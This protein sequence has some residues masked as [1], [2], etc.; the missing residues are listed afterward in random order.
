MFIN[1]KYKMT[2]NKID[3][4]N[5]NSC[6][7]FGLSCK[8]RRYPIFGVAFGLLFPISA[9]TFDLI[10]RGY[11]INMIGQMHIENPFHFVIDMAPLILGFVAYLL[12]LKIQKDQTKIDIYID[13]QTKYIDKVSSFAKEVGKGNYQI[14][15][16]DTIDE[17]DPLF[18]VLV[19]MKDDLLLSSIKEKDQNWVIKGRDK[20]SG[21]LREYTDLKELSYHVLETL[22]NYIGVIQGS[23]YIYDEE[24]KVLVNYATYAYSR[25]K[26][27]NQ[28]FKIGE[29]LI[30]QAAYELDT[31]YRTE[32]PEYYTTITSGILGKKKPGSILIVPLISDEKLRGVIEIA[33]IENNLDKKVIS[34]VEGISNIIG[35]SI[36]SLLINFKTQKLLDES[37]RMTEELQENE[38]ELRQNAEEMIATQEELEKAN[39]DLEQKIKEVQDAQH[40]QY[41]LLENASEVITIYDQQGV[42]QYESPSVKNILGYSHKDTVGTNGLDRVSEATRNIVEET[43][44]NIMK[45]PL[46]PITVEFEYYK[47]DGSLIW[48]E[49]ICRNL[50][51]NPIINGILF[52]TRDITLRKL[53]EKEQR[54]RGQ[55]QAL[56]E[57]SQDLI[58]RLSLQGKIYYVNPVFEKYTG[59]NAKKVNNKLITDSEVNNEIVNFFN[60]TLQLLV[61]NPIIQENEFELNSSLGKRYMSVNSI[62]EFNENKELETIL[63]VAHDI[64][65]RKE[66]EIQIEN[67]N[68]KITESINY[69]KRIQG[70][71]LPQT[72]NLQSYFSDSFIF[73][74]PKDV[75]S[76]DFPWMFTRENNIY[77]AAVDCTGHGVPGA[78]LSF[79]GYFQL[80]NIVDHKKVLDSGVILDKLHYGVRKTLRQDVEGANSR[81]GMDVALCRFDK[82]DNKLYY[83]GAH[84]PLYLLRNGELQEYK[85]DRKAIGGIPYKK[86]KEKNF[87]NYT[88]DIIKGD[89]IFIFSDGYPDQ[90]GGPNRKKYQAK[91]I[92]E[93][94]V[95]NNKFSMTQYSEYFKTEFKNWKDNN[96]QIDDILMIGVEF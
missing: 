96:K 90:I 16:K 58:M 2:T 15:I 74:K 4:I 51:E 67:T 55:M 46:S 71:I 10:Y 36:F 9:W 62:P 45:N 23:F 42:V 31:V 29:G 37:Q 30:G 54:K 88:I 95:K 68:K 22:I 47:K 85:G 21:I 65:E 49:A 61:N 18:N 25:K 72:T 82:N 50:I 13:E 11:G 93:G 6:G 64:T 1:K 40:R 39:I 5:N 48:L 59:V 75:V 78:L 14:E 79:I 91:Q 3:N 19:K 44:E 28:E 24:K 84:R 17:K 20:I 73:Y 43:F 26:F 87:T 8:T 32:I 35:Q 83:S 86:K 41:T 92:R 60:N 27:I 89:K 38:E 63:I 94:I 76:G 52:N 57:N 70:S 34:F 53:A 56:S 80:N 66:I 69:A 33:A 12:A 77:F 81:D 7:A